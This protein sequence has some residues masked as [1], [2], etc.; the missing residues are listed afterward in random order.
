MIT[1]EE[2]K[3]R[4]RAD[5]LN[6]DFQ[7]IYLICQQNKIKNWAQFDAYIKENRIMAVEM[8]WR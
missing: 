1:F 6:K 7:V 8:Y 2:F 3:K 4:V 5:I